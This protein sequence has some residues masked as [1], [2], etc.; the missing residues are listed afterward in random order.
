MEC[1]EITMC[2]LA[3]AISSM[4]QFTL[5]NHKCK[6]LG[7]GHNCTCSLFSN[8]LAYYDP[9]RCRTPSNYIFPSLR[10]RS[11]DYLTNYLKVPSSSLLN[12]NEGSL[13]TTC[14]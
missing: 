1:V 11:P 12:K 14:T 9:K 2:R 13:L 3:K 6:T 8:D 4:N 7:T 5:E 10:S